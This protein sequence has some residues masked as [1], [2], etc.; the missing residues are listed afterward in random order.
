[1]TED[2][3]EPATFNLMTKPPTPAAP[4]PEASTSPPAAPQPPP[5]PPPVQDGAWLWWRQ[6]FHLQVPSNLLVLG[7]GG[8]TEVLPERG[9]VAH[10]HHGAYLPK[11][12]GRYWLQKPIPA[13]W[14]QIFPFENP[15]PVADGK[16]LYLTARD[17]EMVMGKMPARLVGLAF[18][19][20]AAPF[21]LRRAL[22]IASAIFIGLALTYFVMRS[23]GLV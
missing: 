9:P 23:Q 10:G 20:R 3:P 22:I 2:T 15:G 19:G 18:H 6:R 4:A 12:Q 8:R 21:S 7:P 1:L 5:P 11:D 17:V 14:I 16:V 13:G